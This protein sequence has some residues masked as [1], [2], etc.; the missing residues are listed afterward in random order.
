[1]PK[2]HKQLVD[3]LELPL[4]FVGVITTNVIQD[5]A[6]LTRKRIDQQLWHSALEREDVGTARVQVGKRSNQAL[7]EQQIVEA[8]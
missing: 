4:G 7:G 6:E 5:C 8:V 2:H 1:M 3:Q